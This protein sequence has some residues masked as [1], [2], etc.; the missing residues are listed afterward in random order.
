MG[1]LRPVAAI[2]GPLVPYLATEFLLDNDASP[3]G[4]DLFEDG[5]TAPVGDE[6]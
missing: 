5:V 2:V 6:T 4:V 1:I 3:A